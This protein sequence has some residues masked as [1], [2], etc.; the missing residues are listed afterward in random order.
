MRILIQFPEGLKQKA[1]EYA[2]S[3]EKEGNEV[4]ISASPNFG[5]CDLA[6]DEARNLKADKLIHYGHAEF[7]KMDFASSE[8]RTLPLLLLW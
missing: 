5:A 8:A 2:Q 3:L 6:L 1:L 7:N 4:F